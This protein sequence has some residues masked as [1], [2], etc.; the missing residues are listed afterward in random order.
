MLCRGRSRVANT[1][2]ILSLAPQQQADGSSQPRLSLF[3][4]AEAAASL[5][6]KQPTKTKSQ[7][8]KAKAG[9]AAQPDTVPSLDSPSAGKKRKSSSPAAA[10]NP[11]PA[12]AGTVAAQT[13]A[14]AAED[15]GG[16][17]NAQQPPSHKT[18]AASDDAI[19]PKKAK[20]R[21]AEPSPAQDTAAL[22]AGPASEPAATDAPGSVQDQPICAM[23]ASK[24]GRNTGLDNGDK[25]AKRAKHSKKRGSAEPD[26]ANPSAAAPLESE[27]LQAQQ[28]GP[29][30]V[31]QQSAPSDTA[32]ATVPVTE[33][34]K[35][36]KRKHKA[37][38][39]VPQSGA[40]AEAPVHAALVPNTDGARTEAEESEPAVVKTKKR[41]QKHSALGSPQLTPASSNQPADDHFEDAAAPAAI[42]D[43][44]TAADAPA[45]TDA[46]QP[47]EQPKHKRKPKASK[48]QNAAA[49]GEAAGEAAY[50]GADAAA[51]EA[52]PSEQ[53]PKAKKARKP[54]TP[55]AQN[56]NPPAAA[57]GVTSWREDQARTDVKKGKF[58][59]QEKDTLRQQQWHMQS[60]TTSLLTTLPGCSTRRPLSTRTRPWAVG[61]TLL[62]A[63]RTALTSQCMHVAPGC[64]MR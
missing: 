63:C 38:A 1:D 45:A 6:S 22:A 32:A 39:H 15:R 34:Q 17:G 40:Q 62:R 27:P 52:S 54:R 42:P 29:S 41:K 23:Q 3:D 12:K 13:T 35:K 58:S 33:P 21:Q 14:A 31:P 47:G 56:P 18:A 2:G 4:L 7:P 25:K 51:D 44:S 49:A 50:A 24:E 64:C 8:G 19:K 9:T 16:T 11:A 20:K 36:K 57:A 30:T 5:T 10:A 26:M 60:S 46:S 37:D 53:Q 61:A 43:R 59:K 55:K 28:A 48:R